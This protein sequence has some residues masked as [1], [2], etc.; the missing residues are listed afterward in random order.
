MDEI[1]DKTGVTEMHKD[2]VV[3]EFSYQTSL[4]VK[5][6]IDEYGKYGWQPPD[7]CAYPFFW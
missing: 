6:C 4:S 7:R 5:Q 2:M 3:K 1:K